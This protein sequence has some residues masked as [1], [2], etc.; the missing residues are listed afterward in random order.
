MEV[1]ADRID[2]AP[3][4]WRTDAVLRVRRH[5]APLRIV[6]TLDGPAAAPSLRVSGTAR[7][8]LRSA[9]IRVPGFLVRRFVNL[10]VSVQLTRERED[11]GRITGFICRG[12]TRFPPAAEAS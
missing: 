2:T 1:A 5:E 11:A 8:D 10:S 7:L 3:S 6:A 4:G 12:Q 9:G